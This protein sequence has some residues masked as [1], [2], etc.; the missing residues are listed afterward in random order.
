MSRASE[1][2]A[3][4]VDLDGLGGLGGRWLAQYDPTHRWNGWIA[5]PAFDA[6]TVVDILEAINRDSPDGDLNRWCFADDGTLALVEVAAEAEDPT[7]YRPEVIAPDDDGLYRIGASGWVW[8]E[9]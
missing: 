1:S 3:G 8:S 7:T 9:A 2:R 6:Y 4:P 5:C